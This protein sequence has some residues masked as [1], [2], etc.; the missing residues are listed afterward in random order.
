MPG[1][2]PFFDFFIKSKI[3]KNRLNSSKFNQIRSYFLGLLMYL[4]ALERYYSTQPKH[5]F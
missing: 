1:F 2:L 3:L 4:F 5:L